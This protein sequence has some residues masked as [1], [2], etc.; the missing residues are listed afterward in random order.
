MTLLSLP[1]DEPDPVYCDSSGLWWH[2]HE[3]WLTTSGPFESEDLAREALHSRRVWLAAH[4][5]DGAA[6]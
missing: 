1:N 2:W 6:E 3:D 4:R 5:R